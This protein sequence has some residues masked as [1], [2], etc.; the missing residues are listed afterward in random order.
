MAP[1]ELGM[2]PQLFDPLP[3]HERRITSNDC[4]RFTVDSGA[5][6]VAQAKFEKS[7]DPTAYTMFPGTGDDKGLCFK[8]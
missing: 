8:S 5:E 6:D 7:D 3:A 4:N 2:P 1:T